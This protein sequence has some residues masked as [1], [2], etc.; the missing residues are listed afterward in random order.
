MATRLNG[1]SLFTGVYSG[2]NTTFSTLANA[3]A[4]GVTLESITAARSNTTLNSSL[5]QTFAS[6]MQTNFSSFDKDGDGVLSATEMSD[7]TN[8]L[9]TQGM[10]QSQLVQLG[11]ASGLSTGTLEQVLNHFNEVDANKDGKVTMAEISAYGINSEAEKKKTE[12]ANKAATN[13]STF[14]G[15]EDSSAAN[16]SSML[17]YRYLQDENV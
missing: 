1:T 15:N 17:D 12:F 8:N 16:S 3:N 6:Y 7:F 11:S 10:T 9:S 4:D 5:N 14:Y 13:M 2:L